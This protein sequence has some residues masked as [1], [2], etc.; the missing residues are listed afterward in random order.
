MISGIFQRA[1]DPDEVLEYD[2]DFA[3]EIP[4]GATITDHGATGSGVT[5]DS[6]RIDGTRVVAMLS[7][8]TDG[9]NATV[10]FSA[11]TDTSE[12]FERTARLRIRAH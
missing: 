10:T 3:A 12:T 1:K 11:T 8:G 9:A 7:G 6:Y 2:W 4:D 5:V